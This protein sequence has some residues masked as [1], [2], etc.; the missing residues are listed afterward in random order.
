MPLSS[1]VTAL[2]LGRSNG[3]L[4]R[5]AFAAMQ[6]VRVNFEDAHTIKQDTGFVGVYDGHLGD[7]AAAFC[8][9]RLH[10]HVLAQGEKSKSNL[11]SAFLAC[12]EEMKAALPEGSESGSTA[13]VAL[14]QEDTADSLR[15]LIANCGDSRAIL[16]HASS[17]SLDTTSD[18]RPNDP[19]EKARIEAAG[20]TVSD[21]FD[22]PRV[23]GQLACSRALGAFKFKQ[24]SNLQAAAQKI[25]PVPD[26][27]EWKA[28][29]GDWL[30]LGCDGVWDT[31]SSRRIIDEVCKAGNGA[32]LEDVLAKT[33]NLCIEKEA[34]DNLTLIAIQLGAVG[35]MA[36][37][38]H[39]LPGNFLKTKDKEV[40]EQY[41]AFCL[42]FGWTITKEM[43]PKA[44]PAAALSAAT[45]V[46]ALD[47]FSHLPLPAV[48][49][50]NGHVPKDTP[51]GPA[52]GTVNALASGLPAEQLSPLIIAGPSGVGK[53]TL[54][55]KLMDGFPGLYGFSVSSTT[56]APRPGEQ[57]GVDYHFEDLET[58]KKEIEDGK[59]IEHAQVHG[60]LYGT[61]TQAVNSLRESGH[62]CILDIDVQG[63]KQCR[64]K[65]ALS[66]AKFI[67]ISPPS[68]EE[69]EKR[70]RTR[71]TETEEKIQ[72]RIRNA[73]GE[74]E[75]S[76]EDGLF[77]KVLVNDDLG[78]C[79]KAL[80]ELMRT[81]Y[82]FIIQ[83]VKITAKRPI[84]FYIQAA[85][86]MLAGSAEKPAPLELEI[87]A[88][89]S[90]VPT[91]AAVAD[92]LKKDGHSIVSIK[93]G[94]TEV[95]P[96]GREK[97]KNV[98]GISVIIRRLTSAS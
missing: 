11:V 16:W 3:K 26:I 12:D 86:T 74:I 37:A 51:S 64:S 48:K 20:G 76:K 8:A 32:D 55:K 9:Q 96:S 18:H 80:F 94:F 5:C 58:M 65:A 23:D 92:A 77:D 78:Q 82:P 50:E 10:L 14:V 95:V 73:A 75:C 71:G 49:P 29:K 40:I 69:L 36:E 63:A 7:E 22:P 21:D 59:F 84:G 60:N 54:I 79:E 98:A 88:L 91:A 61:S 56:R 31:F 72:T 24:D 39:V 66:D 46:P 97:S 34:D 62:I 53:G 85:K 57:D 35:E 33:L 19:A 52:V 41:A 87:V 27:Y 17:D 1:P 83:Q 45:A 13:T 42:R 70:L 4:G 81:W 68:T 6:G 2:A 30:I 25:S 43:R 44:P 28:V 15:V 89:E 90:A 47:R 93:T 67:F 38:Q